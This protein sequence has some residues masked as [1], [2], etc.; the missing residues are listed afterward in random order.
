MALNRVTAM[1]LENSGHPKCPTSFPVL[2][3]RI[4]EQS[5]WALVYIPG[6]CVWGLPCFSSPIRLL[7]GCEGVHVWLCACTVVLCALFYQY[8]WIQWDGLFDVSLRHYIPGILHH[9]MFF[10]CHLS[11]STFPQSL[12]HLCSNQTYCY[13]RKEITME[14][15]WGMW[16][17]AGS[18][19]I[20]AETW[21][22]AWLFSHAVVST[23][24]CNVLC[25]GHLWL[26]STRHWN[27]EIAPLRARQLTVMSGI[28]Q[29]LKAN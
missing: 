28:L 26:L 4:G 23:L 6:R 25:Q 29:E 8:I 19:I 10:C 11:R 20:L 17:T 2:P 5:A 27:I 21:V 13:S 22:S 15:P 1:S 18:H 24:V 3:R 7:W 14:F 9:S 12:Y 16:Y